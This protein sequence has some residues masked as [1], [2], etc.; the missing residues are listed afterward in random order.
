[1]AIMYDPNSRYE[2]YK[3][4]RLFRYLDNAKEFLVTLKTMHKEDTMYK[5]AKER[6]INP[7]IR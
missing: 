1:M 3:F 2:K 7:E 5:L 4:Y 6:I